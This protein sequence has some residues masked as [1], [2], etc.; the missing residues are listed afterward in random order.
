MQPAQCWIA[1]RRARWS[2]RAAVAV[3]AALLLAACSST[4]T[5]E[6]V[7]PGSDTGNTGSGG[8]G[9]GSTPLRATLTVT[10]VPTPDDAAAA[11]ALGW[12]AGVPRA[13][14]VVQREGSAASVS[15]TSD[16]AGFA[17][18]PDLVTGSYRVSVVRLLSTDESA[19]M[20]PAYGVVDA[21]GGS[22][23]SVLASSGTT[24]TVTVSAGR[25]G[26][27]VISEV[28]ASRIFAPSI[29]D[30]V[31]GQ[32]LELYNNGDTALY[33][34]GK[35]VVKGLPG[36]HDYPNFPC[37]LYAHLHG[38]SLGIW[39]S[40]V[41]RFPGDGDDHLLPPGGVVLIAT[42]AVDHRPIVSGGIDLTGAPFEFR[43]NN[44]VDNPLA[45]DMLSLGPR[46]GGLLGYGLFYYETRE[47]LVVAD[48]LDVATLATARS[49]SDHPLVRVPAAS[50]LDVV[51]LYQDVLNRYPAC[52]ESSV[53]PRFD[54]QDAKLL[55]T[56]D[57]R[58]AQRRV[59]GSLPDGRRI[60]LRTGTSAR[61]L[62]A[63]TPTPGFIP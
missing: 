47:V 4:E 57:T 26:S 27:L 6:V 62:E 19:A 55:T 36:W 51:T 18:F 40:Y 38:D 35:S 50:L 8:N 29:G 54:R 63:A 20:P 9:V 41:Y 3:L 53:H 10:V 33:L 30:Y 22:G 48:R 52:G 7:G 21:W 2:G 31:N 25:R 43:G 34:D 14:V 61:D 1:S 24:I 44:D 11:S 15:A 16:A 17:R 23:T 12:T 56:Y 60:L 37:S 32:F 45:A 5:R 59:I 49:P 58:S 13:Q 39:T 28:T 46:N 42:D